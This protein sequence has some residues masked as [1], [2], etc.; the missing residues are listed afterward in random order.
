M[1]CQ[2][3]CAPLCRLGKS[4]ILWNCKA[5]SRIKIERMYLSLSHRFLFVHV[6]KA[7]GT[8]ISRA[9][10][11]V[12]LP[13][14]RNPLQRV[15]SHAPIVQDP[16]HVYLRQH[17]TAAWARVKLGAARFNSLRRY[18]V[19]RNPYDMAVSYYRFYQK[20]PRL[21]F[22]PGRAHSE[23]PGFVAGMMRYGRKYEQCHW[24]EDQDHRLLVPGLLFFERLNEDF[25]AFT[26]EVGLSDVS[27]GV[28]NV[29]GRGDYR[30]YYD[31]EV[32]EMVET[33]F[34]RDL[35]RFGYDFHSGHPDWDTGGLR[36]QAP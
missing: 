8:S 23:F 1:G 5:S 25:Q 22:L 16:E 9:L 36:D 12:T 18:A 15:I 11:E 35:R 24:I 14:N 21:Q 32:R 27:L 7:A 4:A 20:E 17:D 10:K 3:R 31:D 33:V 28:E 13:R 30:A 2:K 6:P 19:I 29:S 26:E 34:A